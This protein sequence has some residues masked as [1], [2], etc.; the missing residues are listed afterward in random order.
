MRPHTFQEDLKTPRVNR[1]ILVLETPAPAD[2]SLPWRPPQATE[3][4]AVAA[5]AAASAKSEKAGEE[6]AV[7]ARMEIAAGRRALTRVVEVSGSG[8]LTWG[9]DAITLKLTGLPSKVI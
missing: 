9:G 2:E 7:K 1:L 4:D 5:T 8:V 3:D 6:A